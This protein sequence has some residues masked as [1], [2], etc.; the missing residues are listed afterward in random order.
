MAG[1]ANVL[2]IVAAMMA[3]SAAIAGDSFRDLQVAYRC[4]V[5]R[6][7]EQIYATG[8]PKSDRN[9]YLAVSPANRPEHY[10][11]CIFHDA[12]TEVYCEAASG[13]YLTKPNEPR[14]FRASAATMA[15]LAKLGFDTDDSAGNFKIE[16]AVGKPAD[17]NALA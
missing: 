8:D 10:V 1:R 4:E 16:R 17:F 9:R 2:W 5:V 11:Q 12:N 3:N 7:L 15:A 6:R 14:R 13:F